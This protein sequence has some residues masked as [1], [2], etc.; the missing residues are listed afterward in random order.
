AGHKQHLDFASLRAI[1]TRKSIARSANTGISAF[2]NQRGDILQPTNYWEKD[3]IRGVVKTN[4]IKTF[5][6]KN[7]DY[8]ARISVFGAVVL[9]LISLVMRIIRRRQ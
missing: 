8:I 3:V 1:E 5:Y 6:T 4:T 2:V 7:G 9:L